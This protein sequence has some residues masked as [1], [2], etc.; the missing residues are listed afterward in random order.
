[1]TSHDASVMRAIFWMM[2]TDPISC[3]SHGIGSGINVSQDSCNHF[4][5]PFEHDP[6]SPEP[7]INDTITM[8][9]THMITD[10]PG[11]GCQKQFDLNFRYHVFLIFVAFKT[12]NIL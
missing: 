8:E 7:K 4:I 12:L 2:T 1:M 3:C 11:S 9:D 6:T 5:W 10:E